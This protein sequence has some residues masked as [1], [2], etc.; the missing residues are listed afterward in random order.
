[1]KLSLV[2]ILC[3]LS[4]SDVSFAQ[5]ECKNS[6]GSTQELLLCA[7][8]RSPEIESAQMELE[9][10]KAQVK[11]AGQWKN[12]QLSTETFRGNFGGER[13]VETD[14]SIGIPVEIGK[15]SAREAVAQGGVLA[16]EAKLYET[17]AKIREQV[18]VK[19]HRLRQVLHEKSLVEDSI[20]TFSKL[21]GQYSRRPALSPEQKVSASVFELSRSE[22]ELR[23][24]AA[25]NEILE[26][27][28]FFLTTLA[29]TSE[30]VRKALPESPKSWPSLK[31]ERTN[32]Q[33]P[34]QKILR[35]EVERANAELRLARSEAWPTLTLGPSLKM[36]TEG[37]RSDSLVGLNVSLPLPV[38]NVN[39]AAKSAALADVRLSETR[40]SLGLRAEDLKRQELLKVYSDSIDT[41]AKSLSHVDIEKRHADS[42]R[43]FL[44]GVVPSSL[45]IEAH[46]TSFELEKTRHERE[47]KAIEALLEIY[48][49]DGSIL[50][51][52]L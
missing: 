16:A 42:D 26:L 15:I 7:E 17:R 10:A 11:A 4:F 13:R 25:V 39:G 24:S 5:T 32:L 52:N 30:Q 51:K 28:S 43:L 22:Y 31:S 49:I 44:K 27:N 35:A 14:V 21:I 47:L 38:F 37:P 41:L 50:E 46:R 34:Q 23:R 2:L 40:R 29:L 48:T 1:M 20:L 19:L 3:A 8:A 36:Q 45:I 6:V 18:L 12:P 33:S 9:S